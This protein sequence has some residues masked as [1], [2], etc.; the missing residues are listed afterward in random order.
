[1]ETEYSEKIFELISILKFSIKEIDEDIK[2][3]KNILTK[4]N[5]K[6]Y[7]NNKEHNISNK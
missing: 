7:Y 6:Y 3:L 4:Y 2:I 1:M 5:K